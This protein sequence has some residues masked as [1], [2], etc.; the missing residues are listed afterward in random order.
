MPRHTALWVGRILIATLLLWL[1][2]APLVAAL[3]PLATD[4]GAVGRIWRAPSAW[5]WD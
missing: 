4:L 2:A 5:P 1:L 3:W